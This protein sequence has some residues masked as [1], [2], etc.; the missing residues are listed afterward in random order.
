LRKN[1]REHLKSVFINVIEFLKPCLLKEP[2]FQINGHDYFEIMSWYIRHLGLEKKFC[3]QDIVERGIFSCLEYSD[4]INEQ[5][6]KS[7]LNRVK[8]VPDG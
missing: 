5:L 4:L 8:P 2:R 1:R 3:D 7:L 6:F